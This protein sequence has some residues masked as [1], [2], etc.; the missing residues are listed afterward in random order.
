MARVPNGL[1]RKDVRRPAPRKDNSV[2]RLGMR[3]REQ[4]GKGIGRFRQGTC[5]QRGDSPIPAVYLV[6]HR[7]MMPTS[8]TKAVPSLMSV[9]FSLTHRW[10]LPSSPTFLIVRNNRATI[11]TCRIRNKAGFCVERDLLDGWTGRFTSLPVVG[12]RSRGKTASRINPST[13]VCFWRT[14]LIGT[15]KFFSLRFPRRGPTIKGWE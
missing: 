10:R 2:F 8:V 14:C 4:S 6:S 7:R 1:E 3:W 11:R 15:K 13:H 12:F 5:G 9:A